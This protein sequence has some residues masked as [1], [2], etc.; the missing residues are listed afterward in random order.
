[1]RGWL[2]GA[3]GLTALGAV[4]LGYRAIDHAPAK[5]VMAAPQTR[6]VSVADVKIQDMPVAVRGIGTVDPFNTVSIK[7]RVDGAIVAIHF[8]E[9]QTVKPGDPLFEIDPRPFAAQLAQA[10][11]ALQKDQAVMANANA[12]LQ[13][14]QALSAKEYASRQSVDT[15]KALVAQSQAQMAADQAQ[16][17][18]AKLQLNYATIRAPI[19][20]RVGR[21]LVDLGNFI[22]ASDSKPLITLTQI[23]PIAVTFTVPQDVLPEI[24]ARMV[25][26]TLGVEARGPDNQVL[27][28]TGKLA[29]VGDA[30]DRASGTI[31]LKAVFENGDQRLWPGQFVN[32]RLMLR[33][34]PNAVTIPEAAIGLGPD[35]PIAWVMKPD[36][37]VTMRNIEIGVKAQG[38]VAVTKGISRGETVVVE[39]QDGV[40][41]GMR[42]TVSDPQATAAAAGGKGA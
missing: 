3:I 4:L 32:A 20:G 33:T 17:D 14:F 30:I 29:L 5:P 34:L 41:E 28:A 8:E 31:S 25:Q 24:Q 19:G 39:G 16:I 12:D 7:S 6:L 38:A 36:S 37:T 2:T 11:A 18:M 13:R 40:T 27:L 23:Q 1:M 21:R 9:G 42:V 35:G 26:T 15:Q 10:E 22:L